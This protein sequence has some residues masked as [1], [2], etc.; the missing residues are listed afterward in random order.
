MPV[1]GV[2]NYHANMYSIL[3]VSDFH[4]VFS[5][6]FSLW[7]YQNSLYFNG[8]YFFFQ[9]GIARWL[10][11]RSA[12]C[13]LCK[14]DLYEEEEEDDSSNEPDE[15][16][17][18]TSTQPLLSS[19]WNGFS[20]ASNNNNN[21]QLRPA[22]AQEL[23]T[24]VNGNQHQA[25]SA[26]ETNETRSWWPFSLEIAPP[27]EPQHTEEEEPVR[28]S[29]SS[30]SWRLNW[31]GR[32]RRRIIGEGRGG[33]ADALSTELT[34]P[35]IMSSDANNGVDD[36][37]PEQNSLEEVNFSPVEQDPTTT[38]AVDPPPAGG[39][40]NSNSSSAPSSPVEV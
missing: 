23:P 8:L 38:T 34:E 2:V 39:T 36:V 1:L 6:Y 15:S 30:S 35:L 13:P 17:P 21:N 3:L 29:T 27:E 37:Q 32:R 31:F 11:E 10:I 12:V 26:V 33:P 14:L 22:A 19:W 7:S 9:T 40:E 16:E 5:I 25:N 28:N 4:F 20:T 18:T 24:H